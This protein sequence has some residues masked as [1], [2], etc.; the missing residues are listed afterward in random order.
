M[1]NDNNAIKVLLS[2]VGVLH[3]AW[4]FSDRASLINYILITNLMH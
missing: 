3:E 4:H 2:F 1:E